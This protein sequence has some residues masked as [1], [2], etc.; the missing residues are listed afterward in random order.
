MKNIAEIDLKIREMAK[1]IKEL[2]EIEG[3]TTAE[4]AVKTDVSEQEYIDCE[5]GRSDLNF[6]FIYRCAAAFNVDVTDIIAGQSPKLKSYTLTRSGNGQRIEQA[7][8]MTYYNLAA[9]FKNRIAEP[10][11]VCSKY[12]EEA[13]NKPIEVTTHDGQECDIVIKGHLKVQI[14]DHSEILGAG[15]SVYYDSSTPHGMIAVGGEDCEFYAM[16]LNPNGEKIPELQ[17][18]ASRLVSASAEKDTEERVYKKFIDVTE[19]E[20]GTPTSITF[21]NTDNF[22]FAYDIIDG[23]AKK[24]PDKLAML[25][26]SADKKETRFS[27]G[28]IKKYSCRAANY[29]KSFSDAIISSGMPF[30]VLTG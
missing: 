17:P 20:N 25:H 12:R 9:S 16:V 1:R 5:N 21:K 15:D 30:S 14:G 24:S 18:Q 10:L 7:H 28:D 4:M 11:Y 23:I 6:A 26:I 27:F 8:G 13:Q 22:N 2:R 29:F 3:L 19:D